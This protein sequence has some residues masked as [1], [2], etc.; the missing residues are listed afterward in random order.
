MV[1]AARSVLILS[2][3]QSCCRHHN[4]TEPVHKASLC[5]L[6]RMSDASSAS[7]GDNEGKQRRIVVPSSLQEKSK[8]RILMIHGWAQNAS[9]LQVKTKTFTKKLCK[10]GYDVIFLEAPHLLPLKSTIEVEGESV[11]VENGQRIN[12]R[13]WFLFSEKDPADASLSQSGRPMTYFG[14]DESLDLIESEVKGGVGNEN[15]FL[16]GFSQGGVLCHILSQLATGPETRGQSS[17]RSI[18]GAIIASGFAAQH[19]SQDTSKFC[20][21][22][23]SRT[24]I[25]LPSLHIYGV[26]DTSVHPDLSLDLAEIFDGAQLL[27]HEKGHLIPQKSA[28]C[29]TVVKFLDGVCAGKEPGDPA[30]E[31]SSRDANRGETA[32]SMNTNCNAKPNT[33]LL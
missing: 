18:R 1:I 7:F 4:I 17:F 32:K 28:D 11:E 3:L 29:S 26:K 13:A 22:M 27:R 10:A 15:V 21:H 12:A 31:E 19:I 25:S 30:E 8:G 9:V 14:L 33:P 23:P 20:I 24:P 6:A 16:F 2:S 5:N